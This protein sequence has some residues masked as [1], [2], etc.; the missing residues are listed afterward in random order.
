M[1]PGRAASWSVDPK[2]DQQQRIGKVPLS[3]SFERRDCR[4]VRPWPTGCC[5]NIIS[6]ENRNNQVQ[7]FSQS[8]RL[9]MNDIVK[10]SSK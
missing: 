6:K 2:S 9:N 1:H 4:L 7:W 8:E 3:V 10:D 5:T